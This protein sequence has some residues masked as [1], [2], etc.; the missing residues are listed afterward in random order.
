VIQIKSD[1]G[2][3]AVG[4]YKA[5]LRI[6]N[7]AGKVYHRIIMFS[8][9]RT[10]PPFKAAPQVYP[11]ITAP[12]K[13]KLKVQWD[14]L[15]RSATWYQLYAG[16]SDNSAEAQPSGGH[17][18]MTEAQNSTEITD[19]EGDEADSYLPDGIVYYVWVRPGNGEGEGPFSPCGMRKTSSTLWEAFYKDPDGQ[20]F[21]SWDSYTGGDYDKGGSDFYIITPPSEE[22]PGGYL[23]YANSGASG[24]IL[25][26]DT[27]D[28]RSA[29]K[30]GEKLTN[31]NGVLIIKY[32][33][34]HVPALAEGS[35][36]GIYYYGMDSIQT[37]GPPVNTFGPNR[38][39]LGLRL[40][41]FG[42][43]WDLTARRNPEAATLEIA[44][45]RFSLKNVGK[46]I[47][48]IAVP[49]YRKYDDYMKGQ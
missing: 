43:S 40:C 25:Y 24:E 32:K 47:A 12:G 27:G 18:P 6:G 49:W 3:L 15:P 48:F 31:T 33:N 16:T 41:Y 9:A 30:W 11:F 17:V 13:N 14:E 5:V 20:P 34:N 29:S 37:V 46:Y 21:F 4:P 42:N 28:F 38:N 7:E 1:G 44:V 35:H 2:P 22:Y 23:L 39:S 8:V 10:P 45:D 19:I 36:Q 26:H